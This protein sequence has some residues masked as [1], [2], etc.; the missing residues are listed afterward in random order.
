MKSGSVCLVMKSETG[1]GSGSV[2]DIIEQSC[3]ELGATVCQIK[4]NKE[5]A[6]KTK[7]VEYN[8]NED[9]VPNIA[10]NYSNGTQSHFFSGVYYAIVSKYENTMLD[11]K[12]LANVSE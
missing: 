2:G 6:Y 9:V 11:N 3:D 4:T 12:V 8:I 7:A 5:L 10:L 1:N